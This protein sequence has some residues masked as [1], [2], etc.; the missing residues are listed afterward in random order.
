MAKISIEGKDYTVPAITLG[1]LRSGLKD[2]IQ[3]HD[4]F[5]SEGKLF[6]A[7]DQ[8]GA[9]ISEVLMAKYS[10]LTEEKIL[11]ALD[12]ANIRSFWLALL[13]ASGFT[14]GEDQAA[15]PKAT[16]T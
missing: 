15:A 11:M 13:G 4:K 8:Q 3:A 1:Q 6:D 9:I 16:G 5:S 2:K 12:M 14:P 7:I 10:D